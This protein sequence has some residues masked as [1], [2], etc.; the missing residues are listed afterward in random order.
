VVGLS[1]RGERLTDPTAEAPASGLPLA[2]FGF[3]RTDLRRRLVAAILRGE[4]TAT[5]GLLVDYE[6]EG[7]ALP[8]LGSRQVVI[9]ETDGPVAVIET[10]EV[11]VRRMADVDLAFARDEGEGFE[12]VGEWREAH[13]RFFG[14]YI[15]NV[16]ADLGDPTWSLDDDT[17]IVCERFRLVSRLEA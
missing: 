5:A 4:K 11:T 9:D 3:P 2:E 16:R 15:E 17:Q 10:T 13:E 1:R 14:S 6:R 7:S 8:A 12:T